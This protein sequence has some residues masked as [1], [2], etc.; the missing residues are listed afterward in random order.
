MRR[1][2]VL[3]T[4]RSGKAALLT[5][6]S[7]SPS[8]LAVEI[9]GRAGIDGIWIDM[10]HR[11]YTWREVAEMIAGARLGDIDAMP[12]IR[13]GEG[14][15]SFFRPFEDGAAGIMVPHVKTGEE[16]EWIVRNAK[17][18][19][20]GRRGMESVMPDADM[21][22]VDPIEYMEHANRETFVVIQIEDAEAMDNLDDIVSVKGIDAIFVGP[23]DLSA[24]LGVPLQFD[25]RKYRDA[26]AAI[27]AAATRHGKWWGRPVPDATTAAEYAERGARFF[28]VSGDFG[29]LK[30]GF[31]AMRKEFDEFVNVSL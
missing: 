18:V 22:F 11:P 19:P 27:A 7:L 31:L 29:L 8:P 5:N 30:N 12:R 28:N 2:K 6:I 26:E 17:Y 21:S 16:A 23:A 13:K 25:S 3:E 24:S 1:S 20:I 15:T 10:E 14:Y 4:L 9:A